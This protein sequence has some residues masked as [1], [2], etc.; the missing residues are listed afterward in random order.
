[1]PQYSNKP[2]PV[3]HI[4]PYANNNPVHLLLYFHNMYVCGLHSAPW[5][6]HQTTWMGTPLQHLQAN[7]LANAERNK[8][9]DFLL[10]A[11]SKQMESEDDVFTN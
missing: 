4:Q 10:K 3:N 9:G 8:T 7:K 6:T 5:G 2:G 1:M 11:V